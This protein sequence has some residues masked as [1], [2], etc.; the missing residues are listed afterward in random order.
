MANYFPF[1]GHDYYRVHSTRDRQ[2][3]SFI[4][5]CIDDC[6]ISSIH[7]PDML[8]PVSLMLGDEHMFHVSF[9]IA[10]LTSC[11]W[12]IF[13]QGVCRVCRITPAPSAIL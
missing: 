3:T 7:H 13:G 11:A 12:V 4:V 9:M 6:E 10:R 2:H 5:F 1:K 8:E